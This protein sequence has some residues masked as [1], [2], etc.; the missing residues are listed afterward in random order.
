MPLQRGYVLI[1]I[2]H[3]G[4][5]LLH[6]L[7]RLRR[8]PMYEVVEEVL[9]EALDRHEKRDALALAHDDYVQYAGRLADT[10]EEAPDGT[11][12]P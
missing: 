12:T 9:R 10:G 2:R 11:R 5:K 3:S 7:S 8:Q 1:Q 4:R 6:E